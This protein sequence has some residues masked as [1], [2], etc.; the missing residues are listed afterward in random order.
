MSETKT[1][2]K[3]S[4]SERGA[5]LAARIHDAWETRARLAEEQREAELL[6]IEA[7]SLDIFT[8]SVKARVEEAGVLPTWLFLAKKRY[9]ELGKYIFALSR[10]PMRQAL[11]AEVIQEAE[12]HVRAFVEMNAP[13][14]K[15]LEEV[16]MVGVL[17]IVHAKDPLVRA[18]LDSGMPA[19][20]VVCFQYSTFDLEIGK[21][22]AL[23]VEAVA[24]LL[25]RWGDDTPRRPTKWELLSL[26]WEQATGRRVKR[27]TW[28]K[29]AHDRKS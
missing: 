19:E 28:R 16:F 8:S 1:D 23:H 13:K 11:P 12:R 9:E 25:E 22:L 29:H 14:T 2:E 21:R 24:R 6:A 3:D 20:E 18:A 10:A 7:S 17:D 15:T 4:S 5:R 26:L 27:G